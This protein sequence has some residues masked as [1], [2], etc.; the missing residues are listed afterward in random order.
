MKLLVVDDDVR[1]RKMIASI[2]SDLTDEI[3][4]SDGLQAHANYKTHQ[5]DWVLMDLLM[6]EV[7]GITA[8]RQIKTSDPNAKIIIVT[9]YDSAAMRENARAAGAYAYVLKENIADL[10]SIILNV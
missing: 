8:T 9:T 4:E 7:D 10:P 5:P 2:V 6:P 1:I 3:F